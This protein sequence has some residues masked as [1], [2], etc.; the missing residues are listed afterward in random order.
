MR[1]DGKSLMIHLATSSHLPVSNKH[2]FII[3]SFFFPSWNDWTKRKRAH[4]DMKCFSTYVFSIRFLSHWSRFC[5]SPCVRSFSL[6][7]SSNYSSAQFSFHLPVN[8]KLCKTS[9]WYEIIWFWDLTTC[10]TSSSRW[11]NETRL[12]VKLKIPYHYVPNDCT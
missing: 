4:I 2:F 7:F 1:Y 3:Q 12:N 9:T 8:K 6:S 11:L 5:L 10:R